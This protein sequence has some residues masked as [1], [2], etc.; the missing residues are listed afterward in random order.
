MYDL[1][2]PV[3]VLNIN[4]KTLYIA[5]YISYWFVLIKHIFH[6]KPIIFCKFIV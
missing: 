4:F 6:S 2:S 3:F 5:I 1:S